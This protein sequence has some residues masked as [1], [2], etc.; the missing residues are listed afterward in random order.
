MT[1]FSNVRHQLFPTYG[2]AN[3]AASPGY[4][5]FRNNHGGSVDWTDTLSE[6]LTHTNITKWRAES[7]LMASG[8]SRAGGGPLARD[9]ETPV[10]PA[11]LSPTCPC[12]DPP[13][14]RQGDGALAAAKGTRKRSTSS[15]TGPDR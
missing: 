6:R 13:K 3:P 14:A 2:Y 8:A 12:S 5:H 15:W 11:I 7:S 9:R 10:T 1:G 4:L